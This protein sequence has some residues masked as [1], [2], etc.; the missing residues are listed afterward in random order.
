MTSGADLP[1]A[2]AAIVDDFQA[3]TEPD[4]LQLLLE[5][6][7]SLPELPEKYADHPDLLEPVP[8]C[9]SPVFLT[10]E[11]GEEGSADGGGSLG[12]DSP[13][14]VLLTAP[15]ESP[16]TRGFAAILTDG[17]AGLTA[18]EV[19]AVPDDVSHRLGLDRAVS[20]LRLRGMAG[21]LGRI[22][23]QVREQTTAA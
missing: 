16:T 19:L 3:L 17:L 5:F 9:Q 8:E 2:F 10:V 11:V 4:R 23:R 14:R 7:E 13:V 20:P 18:A 1:S 15:R 22:K 12:P 21:M 6:A